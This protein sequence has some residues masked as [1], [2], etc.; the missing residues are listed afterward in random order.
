MKTASMFVCVVFNGTSAQK[1]CVNAYTN[2]KLENI[3]P[4]AYATVTRSYQEKNGA[5]A[6][7]TSEKAPQFGSKGNSKALTKTVLSTL[8]TDTHVRYVTLDKAKSNYG[9]TSNLQH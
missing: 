1:G 2:T 6:L 4:A 7:N 8:K 3:L 9:R 5:Q